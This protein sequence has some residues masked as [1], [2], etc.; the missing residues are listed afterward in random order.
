MLWI[1]KKVLTCKWLCK[2]CVIH[3]RKSACEVAERACNQRDTCIVLCMQSFFAWAV[4]VKSIKNL[5]LLQLLIRNPSSQALHLGFNCSSQPPFI[6]SA[7]CP[8]LCEVMS[9]ALLLSLDCHYAT[10]HF[11]GFGMHQWLRF[12]FELS[13]ETLWKLLDID[14]S[15]PWTTVVVVVS[16][17]LV[18]QTA[19][20]NL[21]SN[22]TA[23][24]GKWALQCSPFQGGY[25]SCCGGSVSTEVSQKEQ[26]PKYILMVPLCCPRNKATTLGSV[27]D[28]HK[29]STLCLLDLTGPPAG[30]GI[31]DSNYCT[32][33]GGDFI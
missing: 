1:L 7:M 11:S 9:R 23:V 22:H 27:P 32:P 14:P 25:W 24:T 21:G 10:G 2:L 5:L 15:L 8:A 19:W 13:R 20:N 30:F 28:F 3:L 4:P 29:L 17:S 12:K 16:P 26:T 18:P 33:F 6:T 31:L